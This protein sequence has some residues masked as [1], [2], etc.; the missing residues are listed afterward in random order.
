MIPIRSL[1]VLACSLA[2]CS[3][4]A[5]SPGERFWVGTGV[6]HRTLEEEANGARLLSESGPMLEVRAGGR[7]SLPGGGAVAGELSLAGGSLDYDGQTQAGVPLQTTSDHLDATARLMWR[8]VAAQAWG[9]PWLLLGW[10][11]NRRNIKGKAM[12]S[13]LREDSSALLVGVRL[14]S[15]THQATPQW[16][17]RLEGEALVS[18]RHRLDVDFMGLYDRAR[19]DG[20]R[21]RRTAV[22]LV[23]TPTGSPWDWTFEWAHLNQAVSPSTALLRGGALMGS[24]RQ[25][26]LSTDDVTLRVS[27]RF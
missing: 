26:R 18:L 21:Q 13:G 4:L 15:P 19:L 17:L 6:V 5:Q 2:A 14:H 7:Q 25:P 23:A 11:H 3:A 10:H 9:E 20:G 12:V 27:R 24:V 16:Q 22:R 8:P 1:A